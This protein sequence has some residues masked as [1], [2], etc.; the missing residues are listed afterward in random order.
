MKFD[1]GLI[2]PKVKTEHIW[3]REISPRAGIEPET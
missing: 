3:T 1:K 2:V